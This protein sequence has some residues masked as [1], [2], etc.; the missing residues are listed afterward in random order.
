M[1]EIAT[2]RVPVPLLGEQFTHESPRETLHSVLELTVM[3]SL[4]PSPRVTEVDETLNDGPS[5]EES[6]P[7]FV[8]NK[9]VHT[10][11]STVRIVLFF[12]LFYF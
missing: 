6:S 12:M 9:T 2:C 7:Q 5:L 8:K 10:P 11:M 3:V 4:L 1:A